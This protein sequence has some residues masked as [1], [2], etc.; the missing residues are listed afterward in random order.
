MRTRTLHWLKLLLGNLGRSRTI[1]LAGEMAFWMFLSLLP[2]AAVAGLVVARFAMTGGSAM[3]AGLLSTVPP[4]VRDLLTQELSRVS[5]W[6]EGAVGP[7]AAATFVW[8]A[9]SGVHAIFDALELETEATA[10]PWWKKRAF[11]IVACIALAVG[12][13][14]IALLAAGLDFVRKVSGDV[15]PFFDA[16]PR[17]V[18][19]ALRLA[20]SAAIAVALV[21]G[22]YTIG[23]P[24]RARRRMPV[25]P[26]A[27]VA[28]VLQAALGFGYGAYV[29]RVGD[30]GAYQAG[31]AVIGVTLMVLYLFSIAILV[32]AEVNQMIGVRRLLEASVHPPVAAPPPETASMR[33]CDDP[34]PRAPSESLRPSLAGT[35]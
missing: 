10:R 27:I 18:T 11:A 29:R 32:G 13:A 17:V 19:M 33:R 21:A 7:A 9:S 16:I 20:V 34:P 12:V 31:L 25:L 8:L 30:S 35:A 15:L 23:L 22:L 3:T 28:V 26:G 14:A 4:A 1:G 5:A 6:N 24:P 2:L